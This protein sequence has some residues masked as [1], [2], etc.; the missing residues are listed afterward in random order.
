[1]SWGHSGLKLV[2]F[3]CIFLVPV[4][5]TAKYKENQFE[6]AIN[7]ADAS[8]MQDTCQIIMN[9]VMDLAHH[10]LSVAQW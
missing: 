4:I 10:E 1:M 6:I 7:I 2:S 9:L 3:H 8:S 5:N